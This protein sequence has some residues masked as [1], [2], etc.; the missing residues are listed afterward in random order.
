MHK[1]FV[2]VGTQ[3]PFDRLIRAVDQWAEQNSDCEIF[4]QIGESKYQPSK[5][6]FSRFIELDEYQHRIDW[7]DVMVAHAGIGAILSALE[8]AKPIIIMPRRASLKE[9]RNEHQLAT[10]GRFAEMGKVIV[11]MD[12]NELSLKLNEV[13]H[14]HR[15]GVPISHHASP[16]LLE[17][18]RKFL[19]QEE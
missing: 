7:C 3:V 2:S 13:Q 8:A 16:E 5:I 10:A 17:A 6:Q 1:M 4:A 19:F 18:V 14:Q 15:S 11:A 9:H 12:E